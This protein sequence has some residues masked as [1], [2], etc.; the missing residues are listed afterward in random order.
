MNILYQIFEKFKLV[1]DALLV[2]ENQCHRQYNLQY[3]QY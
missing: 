1:E 2:D 3:M